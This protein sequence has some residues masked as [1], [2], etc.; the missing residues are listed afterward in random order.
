MPRISVLLAVHNGGEYLHEAIAS[1]QAQTHRDWE[2]LIVSNGS[3]D[4]TVQIAR[5]A[6]GSD[7]RVRVVEIEERNKNRAYNVGYS[8]ATGQ[9]ICFFAADDILTPDSLE[10]RLAAVEGK[11][12]D[13][14]ATCCLQT[15]STDP[16]YDGV[17]YPRNMSKSNHSGGSLFFTRWLA[18]RIFPIPESQ[19]NEDTWASLHLQAFGHNDHVSAAL[20]RYRIHPRNSYGYGVPFETKRRQYLHRMQAYELFLKRY[21]GCGLPYLEHQVRPF[22]AG[23]EA[24]RESDIPAILRVRGLGLGS[25]AVLTLYSSERLY[26]VRHAYFRLLSG[27]IAK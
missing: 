7:A 27:G 1:V 17:M 26:K 11:G 14:Y 4:N 25:K 18:D 8:Q 21:E 9:Y 13:H 5:R 19:P 24:A 15:F 3:T 2:L 16:R 12:D 20:Y 6:T 23:L 10:R 22:L